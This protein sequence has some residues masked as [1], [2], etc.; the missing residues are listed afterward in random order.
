MR[1]AALIAMLAGA[2]ALIAAAAAG[3]ISPGDVKSDYAF[4]S[5][6]TQ[7]MQDDD[8]ANPGMLG[9]LAGAALW[10]AVPDARKAC[11][12]CHG[13]AAA[14][15]A[16]VAARYPAFDEGEGRAVD[17]EQRINLCRTRHQ[18]APALADESPELLALA[19]FVA[20]QSRGMP[21]TPPADPRLASATAAGREIF[22]RR[23]GQLNLSCSQCHDERFGHRL[24][25]N[26]VPQG[27]PSGYPVYRLEWQA[28]GSLQRRLRACMI[29]MRAEPYPYGASEAV[30][31]A[32]YLMQRARGLPME[33]PAVRP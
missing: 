9:V 29:G 3:G 32:L 2:W 8:A 17:L 4:M 6:E 12:G 10:E 7:A 28:L 21:I 15:M 18:A 30:A 11:A 5:R 24:A 16:G 33:T 14:S 27:H 22:E 20:R 19:A 26:V 13:D 1:A 23:Q 31:L 25:G